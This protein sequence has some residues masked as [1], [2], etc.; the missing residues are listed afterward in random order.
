MKRALQ[1]AQLIFKNHPNNPKI[2]VIPYLRE[3]VSASCDLSNFNNEKPLEGFEDFDWTHM[4]KCYEGKLGNIDKMKEFTRKD[5]INEEKYE[6]LNFIKESIFENKNGNK[7]EKLE[8]VQEFR[9]SIE[10]FVNFLNYI[11]TDY[12]L[13]DQ[14]YIAIVSHF[15]TL[16]YLVE[17][18]VKDKENQIIYFENCEIKEFNF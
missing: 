1:T 6:I 3:R 2:C 13:E 18:V 10:K 11:K 9:K 14:E 12:K 15:G 7:K 16:K 8:T 4:I 17:N 5:N